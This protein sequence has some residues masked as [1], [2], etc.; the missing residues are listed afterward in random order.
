MSEELNNLLDQLGAAIDQA[1]E[2]FEEGNRLGASLCLRD[3][4]RLA[5][6]GLELTSSPESE[7]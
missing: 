6:R 7:G 4:E 3:A 1:S 2:Y 5:K